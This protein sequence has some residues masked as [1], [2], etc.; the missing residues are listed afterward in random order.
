MQGHLAV[1]AS[2]RVSAD[3][4]SRPNAPPLWVFP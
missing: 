2:R 4:V 1:E 3:E